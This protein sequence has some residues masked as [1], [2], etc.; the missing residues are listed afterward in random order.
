MT[1][2][3]ELAFPIVSFEN[4]PFWLCSSRM[5]RRIFLSKVRKEWQ[6]GSVTTREKIPVDFST[7]F[8]SKIACRKNRG[9]EERKKFARL[10]VIVD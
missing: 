1:V 2:G 3:V 8:D 10:C 5:E 4:V 6:A 7:S 9:N